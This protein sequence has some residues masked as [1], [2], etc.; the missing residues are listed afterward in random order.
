MSSP[1]LPPV[2]LAGSISNETVP[3]IKS[4]DEGYADIGEAYMINPRFQIGEKISS[5]NTS[6]VYEGEDIDAQPDDCEVAIKIYYDDRREQRLR[7]TMELAFSEGLDHPN[8]LSSIGQGAVLLAQDGEVLP[9][10]FMITPLANEGTL[11]D[12]NIDSAEAADNL[13]RFIYETSLALDEMQKQGLVHR[14]VKPSNIFLNRD[15]GGE[16]HAQLGDFNFTVPNGTEI[17]EV[18]FFESTDLVNVAEQSMVSENTRAITVGSPG[19]ISPE[20]ARGVIDPKSD[21]YSLART[22]QRKNSV[23]L[24]SEIGHENGYTFD[25]FGQAIQRVHPKEVMFDK[26]L[27]INLVRALRQALS[28][29]PD[30]R[31]T[32]SEMAA[33]AAT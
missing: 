22:A 28:L 12:A 5:S 29:N 20:Q 14:D 9:R 13:Q 25:E 33:A 26:S 15:E 24:F 21:I 6:V 31:P 1:E 8:L 4:L 18:P 23:G 16:T 11:L 3:D 2:E 10:R 27:S 17:E 19:Y 32:A 30:D 7:D